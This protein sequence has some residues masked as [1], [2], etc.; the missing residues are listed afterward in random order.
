VRLRIDY[1][2]FFKTTENARWN[3]VSDVPWADFDV[4]HVSE[5][6]LAIVKQAAI[7]EAYSPTY[8][9]DVLPLFRNEPQMA[10]FISIQYYEEYKH[11]HALRLYLTRAGVELADVDVAGE[12]GAAPGYLDR[13]TCCLK[14]GVSEVFT[15]VFYEELARQTR[16]PVLKVLSSLISKDEW[17][18]LSWYVSYIDGLLDEYPERATALESAI[19]G[20][21]HQGL[22]ALTSWVDFWAEVGREYTGAKPYL[23]LN[24]VLRRLAGRR[25]STRG[26][27]QLVNSG[28]DQVFH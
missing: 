22:D 24:R 27:A 18:H 3:L 1:P 26:L 21:Q 19:E 16:C 25:V 28:T 7:V 11:S 14:F 17:R 10:G 13:L 23:V 6:E 4:L 15:A 5:R 20:Y 9:T 8:A 2:I 12:D